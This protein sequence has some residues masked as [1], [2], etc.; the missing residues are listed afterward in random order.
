LDPNSGPLAIMPTGPKDF[1]SYVLERMNEF[2][3]HGGR[4]VCGRRMPIAVTPEE[5]MT[6]EL[7]TKN[8]KTLPVKYVGDDSRIFVYQSRLRMYVELLEFFALKSRNEL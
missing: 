3:E 5:T 8:M 2:G 7:Y 6:K 1:D 4:S